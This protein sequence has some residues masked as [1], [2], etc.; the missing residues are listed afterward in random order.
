MPPTGPRS[1]VG[2]ARSSR[3]ALRHGLT[4]R[5]PLLPNESRLAWTHHVTSIRDELEPLGYLEESY[6]ARI[7]MLLWRLQRVTLFETDSLTE[8]PSLVDRIDAA[9]NESQ[10][11]IDVRKLSDEELE[12]LIDRGDQRRAKDAKAAPGRTVPIPHVRTEIV[13]VMGYETHLERQLQR[14]FA[15]LR[16]LKEGR[17]DRKLDR[18]ALPLPQRRRQRPA[19]LA[20]CID[21]I[22]DSPVLVVQTEARSGDAP[23]LEDVSPNEA[24]DAETEDAPSTDTVV[25]SAPPAAYK[26][27][28]PSMPDPALA[29]LEPLRA[30]VLRELDDRSLLITA[31][32]Q[33]RLETCTDPD[34]LERWRFRTGLVQSADDLFE[35]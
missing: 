20:P 29:D 9:E 35:E 26:R 23:E 11:H 6:V 24:S 15:E 30:A 4:A 17:T 12:E 18:H 21:V 3:N 5:G 22:A 14:A 7:A 34:V 1:T 2:K 31:Y 33:E 10:L 27:P 13:T 28:A 19:A 16:A 25:L 32:A 8:S